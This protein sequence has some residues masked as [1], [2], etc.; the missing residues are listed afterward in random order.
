MGSGIISE[1][2]VGYNIATNRIYELS[3]RMNKDYHLFISKNNLMVKCKNFNKIKD[4]EDN[5]VG[6]LC[7]KENSDGNE[8]L[9]KIDGCSD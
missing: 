8:L 9:V 7:L 4:R 5:E 1:N 2:I 3:D 6:Y